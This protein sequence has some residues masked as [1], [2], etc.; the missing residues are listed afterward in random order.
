LNSLFK[1]IE[2]PNVK[3]A[4]AAKAAKAEMQNGHRG[5]RLQHFSVSHRYFTCFAELDFKESNF[6]KVSGVGT[7]SETC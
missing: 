6:S 5:S 4:K 2:R 1:K 3:A 7:Q